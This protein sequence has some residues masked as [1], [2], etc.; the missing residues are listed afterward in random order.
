MNDETDLYETDAAYVEAWER[1]A[2]KQEHDAF[3]EW[4]DKITTD[5]LYLKG[6]QDYYPRTPVEIDL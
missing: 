5:P 6:F 2:W 4:Y 3:V 1:R